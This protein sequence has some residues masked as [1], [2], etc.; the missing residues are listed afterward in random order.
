MIRRIYFENIEK[1]KDYVKNNNIKD[2]YY[3]TPEFLEN[4]VDLNIKEE[5]TG[6]LKTLI[7]I[8]RSKTI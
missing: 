8:V 3:T 1:A 2:Y 4:G 5:M 7:E 6:K